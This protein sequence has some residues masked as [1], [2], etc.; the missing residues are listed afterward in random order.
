MKA[1]FY[2]IGTVFVL[3]LALFGFRTASALNITE[4]TGTI[5]KLH[6][7]QKISGGEK[8][9]STKMRYLIITKDA[10]YIST[11]SLLN[12]KFDNS[13]LFFHLEE[14][15]T[16]KFKLSGYGKSFFTDYKNVL[17]AVEVQPEVT[18]VEKPDSMT[19]AKSK[20]ILKALK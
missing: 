13:D 9:V 7:Q 2:I 5:T 11:S 8:S 20:I 19:V 12:G 1:Y 17:E 3:I 18:K 4:E 14:G 6:E 16:Y 15:K 10:T